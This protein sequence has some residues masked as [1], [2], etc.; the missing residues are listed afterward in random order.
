MEGIA[1]TLELIGAYN[2]FLA[3]S[4][5]TTF[6]KINTKK[7]TFLTNSTVFI[8]EIMNRVSYH[9]QIDQ[10]IKGKLVSSVCN[11]Y[12]YTINHC[13][14]PILVHSMQSNE[15]FHNIMY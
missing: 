14:R 9:Y 10:Q 8:E 13:L 12:K 5:K 4:G 7:L 3:T 15:P 11:F 1:L 2:N 6:A